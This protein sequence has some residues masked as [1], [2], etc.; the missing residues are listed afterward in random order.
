M[1]LPDLKSRKSAY[2]NYGYTLLVVPIFIILQLHRP[3]NLFSLRKSDT[4]IIL[5]PS[6]ISNTRRSLSPV[7]T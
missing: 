1:I 3:Y 4:V 6:T 2:P 7:I 5:I